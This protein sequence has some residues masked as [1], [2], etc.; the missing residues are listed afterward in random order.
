MKKYGRS[1]LLADLAN[2]RASS[3]EELA[4]LRVL[5]FGVRRMDGK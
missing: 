3:D 4:Q 5:K 1:G 2:C